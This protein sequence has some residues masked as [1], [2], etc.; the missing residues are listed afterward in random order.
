MTETPTIIKARRRRV[1]VLCA[2]MIE[3]Q[4]LANRN[5]YPRSM[6]D[7]LLAALTREY[8]LGTMCRLVRRK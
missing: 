4:R 7:I 2:D 5:E 6:V 1:Q 3:W 8:R